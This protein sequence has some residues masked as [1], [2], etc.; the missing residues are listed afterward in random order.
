VREL[1]SQ[2]RRASVF[3]NT[4]QNILYRNAPSIFFVVSLIQNLNNSILFLQL[5]MMADREL[6]KTA[7]ST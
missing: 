3:C 6:E 2:R 1:D 7:S 4:T 5:N